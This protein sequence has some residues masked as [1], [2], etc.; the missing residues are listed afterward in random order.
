MTQIQHPPKKRVFQGTVVSHKMQKTI[1]VEMVRVKLHPKYG[2]RYKV[3]SRYKV[4][5]EKGEYRTGDK[6]S[7]IECRPLSKEKRWRVVGKVHDQKSAKL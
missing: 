7:F 2:K 1:V 4:H 3:S 5:D 6:V